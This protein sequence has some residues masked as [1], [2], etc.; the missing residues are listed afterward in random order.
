MQKCKTFFSQPLTRNNFFLLHWLRANVYTNATQESFLM[1][2]GKVSIN[3]HSWRHYTFSIRLFTS[4][5]INKPVFFLKNILW[6]QKALW[7]HLWKHILLCV[8]MYVLI[9]MYI[10]SLEMFK[11]FS[12]DLGVKQWGKKLLCNAHN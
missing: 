9:Y 11:F 6:E 12:F 5:S 1:I 7:I 10:F 8:C 2:I 3:I 4:Y